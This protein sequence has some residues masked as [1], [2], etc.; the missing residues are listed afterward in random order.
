MK[1]I[2]KILEWWNRDYLDIYAW[3]NATREEIAKEYGELADIKIKLMQQRGVF[4]KD[5]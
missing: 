4:P 5:K 2:K 1:L 3:D